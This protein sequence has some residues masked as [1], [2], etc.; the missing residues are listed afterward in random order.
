MALQFVDRSPPNVEDKATPFSTDTLFPY[1]PARV[2]IDKIRSQT[3]ND[4]GDFYDVEA[5]MWTTLSGINKDNINNYVST[6]GSIINR[7]N[8]GRKIDQSSQLACNEY[9][10][11]RHIPVFGSYSYPTDEDFDYPAYL[12]S[13]KGYFS[14]V[15]TYR[16]FIVSESTI[17]SALEIDLETPISLANF[18]DWAKLRAPDTISDEEAEEALEQGITIRTGLGWDT[19]K[20]YTIYH[21]YP[22]SLDPIT[23]INVYRKPHERTPCYSNRAG[24]VVQRLFQPSASVLFIFPQIYY[25]GVF[26]GYAARRIVSWSPNFSYVGIDSGSA[27]GTQATICVGGWIPY[28]TSL[29]EPPPPE[30][31][32]DP[33]QPFTLA[34]EFAYVEVGEANFICEATAKGVTDLTVNA[35]GMSAYAFYSGNPEAEVPTGTTAEASISLDGWTYW[36]KY[37]EP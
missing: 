15:E 24:V 9:Y 16:D 21:L 35:A 17:N 3:A 23:G 1:C 5:F 32:E 7:K 6:S 4:E 2:D 30:N 28:D 29:T 14:G 34:R 37:E 12:Y 8:L 22:N 11:L 13:I 25:R 10:N 36:D 31:P 18:E 26:V 33:E 19:S 20:E 27:S